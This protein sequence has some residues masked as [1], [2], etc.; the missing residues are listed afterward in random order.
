VL[1]GVGDGEGVKVEMADTVGDRVPRV[2]E[3]S[4]PAAAVGK[5]GAAPPHP[6][7]KN[8]NSIDSGLKSLLTIRL[9]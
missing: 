6:T 5:A 9:L 3:P 4:E 8:R 7:S 1:V 2:G